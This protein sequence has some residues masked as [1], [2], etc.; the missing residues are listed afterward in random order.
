MVNKGYIK[1]G[2]VQSLTGFFA[3]PKGTEDVRVV[4]NATKSGLN[5]AIWSPNFYLPTAA[6]VLNNSDDTTFYG[7]I[8]LGEMFLNY[9]LDPNLRA[10]AGVDV[11]ELADELGEK[12]RPGQ[13]L[14][15]RSEQALLGV[16]S[17]PFNCVRAY[18]LSEDI[19]CGDWWAEDNPFRWD[20]VILNLPGTST[21]DPGKPWMY[22]YDEKVGKMAAFVVSY[23]DDLRTGDHGSAQR[24]D[25]VMHV[26]A[27]RINYLGQQDVSRKHK[28]ASQKP[29]PR[30]G[31]V[32]VTQAGEGLYLTI[33]LEKWNKAKQILQRYGEQLGCTKP[34]WDVQAN[35]WLDYK[36]LERDTGFLVHVMMTFENLWPYLKGF[37][38]TMNGW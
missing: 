28:G 6:T 37:Y 15:M 27:S 10:R 1:R 3:V 17:S 26:G 8:N 22:Q 25:R 31:S 9:Y 2:F 32:L 21:Y 7:D 11:T 4:Y 36:T 30:A 12:L 19:I 35:I 33:S 13:Q 5:A 34:V 20:K 29:G 18:L 24:C 23:V 14:F 38:L 16:R